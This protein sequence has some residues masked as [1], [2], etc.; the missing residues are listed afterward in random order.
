MLQTS[1]LLEAFLKTFN[2][3]ILKP[4]VTA[5]IEKSP[6][7]YKCIDTSDM[8]VT[9]TSAQS[10]QFFVDPMQN[11]YRNNEKASETHEI[12]GSLTYDKFGKLI[13][14]IYSFLFNPYRYTYTVSKCSN[15]AP[16]Y[17]DP[18]KKISNVDND[19][20]PIK[21]SDYVLYTNTNT[22]SNPTPT[23]PQTQ[24][25]FLDMYNYPPEKKIQAASSDYEYYDNAYPSDALYDTFSSPVYY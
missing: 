11:R 14:N 4:K 19:T 9:T 23:V 15:D 21:I 13:P 24:M 16:S 2:Q 22:R 12:F 1:Y 18:N 20:K 7:V 6:K 25:Q 5:P 3:D 8:A 10:P 17:S